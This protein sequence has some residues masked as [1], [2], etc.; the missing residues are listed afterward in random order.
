MSPHTGHEIRALPE[1]RNHLNDKNQF[2]DSAYQEFSFGLSSIVSRRA[3]KIIGLQ[4]RS[5]IFIQLILL[6]LSSSR[7][8]PVLGQV[9]SKFNGI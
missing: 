7:S 1:N 2:L 6:V 9:Q 4:H 8:G 3:V 5:H